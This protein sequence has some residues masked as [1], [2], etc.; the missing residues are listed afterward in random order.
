[1]RNVGL[2]FPLLLWLCACA[3]QKPLDQQ[4][5]LADFQANRD[6]LAELHSWHLQG[7][8]ALSMAREAWSATL[9]WTQTP[10]NYLLRL[11]APLGRGSFELRG[12]EQGVLLRLAPNQVLRARDPESLLQKQFG[13]QVPVTGLRYWVR[14]IPVPDVQIDRLQLDGQGRISV[15]QQSGWQVTYTDYSSQGGYEL[16]GRIAMANNA[17]KL[18]LVIKNWEL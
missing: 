5:G 7:R 11:I 3:T 8:L 14:G 15:L 17:L 13:W 4:A 2:C 9:Q 18:R 16:P 12:D 10:E 1:M 6:R